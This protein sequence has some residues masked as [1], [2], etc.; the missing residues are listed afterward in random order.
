MRKKDFG[1]HFLVD[2]NI[3]SDEL[4]YAD[5]KQDDIV[6]EIGPGKGALT[7]P[8]A[9][10]VKQVIAIE[11]DEFLYESLTNYIPDNVVLIR[12]DALT[13][14]FSTIPRF[15]KIVS[16]LPYKISSPI[17]FNLLS[18]EFEKA[19]L[20][21]QMEFAQRM[22][23]KPLMKHYSRLS[24]NVYY[25]AQCNML[26]KVSRN[27]FYP[28]PN[29]DSYIIQLIPRKKPAFKVKNEK[30]FFQVVKELF[31]HRRKKIKNI[32]KN[33]YNIEDPNLPFAN[34]RVEVL[35]PEQIAK[36]SDFLSV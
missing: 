15:N 20:M 36:I 4:G 23:A 31:N 14:D 35:T 32:I 27:C 5:L 26:K 29:V 8:M 22:I 12:A 34:N 16:N 2:K 18:L 30:L 7:I 19:V 10:H 28:K 1:Q 25:Y 33:K 13:Y 6:L 3:I 9:E 17:T 11:K 21:Y 24:V